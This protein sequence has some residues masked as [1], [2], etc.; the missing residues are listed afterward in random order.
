[1]SAGQGFQET[2]VPFE[3]TPIPP[4]DGG[5]PR[6]F[7]GVRGFM[8]SSFS[9]NPLLARTFLLDV[10]ATEDA[11]LTIGQALARP[12]ALESAYEQALEAEPAYEAFGESA[13]NGDPIQAIPQMSSVFSALGQAYTLIYQQQGTPDEAFENAAEQVRTVTEPQ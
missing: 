6:P 10:I 8:Q 5:T 13:E 7:V 3:V 12:P 1:V 11:Q 4:V 2:G 9:E